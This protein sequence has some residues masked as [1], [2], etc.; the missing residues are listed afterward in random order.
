MNRTAA[1]EIARSV[2]KRVHQGDC[3]SEP[4]HKTE[5]IEEALVELLNIIELTELALADTRE[6]YLN[7]S[8]RLIK[9]E[10]K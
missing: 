9:A 3:P 8:A 4:A 6:A 10:S 2:R 5:V 1:F 7:Q